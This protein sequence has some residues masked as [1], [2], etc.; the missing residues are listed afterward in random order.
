MTE[1]LCGSGVSTSCAGKTV[2]MSS[3]GFQL[4]VN[5]AVAAGTFILSA[6]SQGAAASMTFNQMRALNAGRCALVSL[7]DNFWNFLAAIYYAAKQFG[8]E[9]MVK[10]KINE[11][12]PY[13]CTCNE[14]ADK[15]AALMGGNAATAGVMSACSDAAQKLAVENGSA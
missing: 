6:A 8:K 10:D 2:P 12:Y 5:E 13:V 14:D 7:G 1:M 15:F 3:T 4:I 9:N 11:Y